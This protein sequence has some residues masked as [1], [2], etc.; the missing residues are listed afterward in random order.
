MMTSSDPRLTLLLPQY[1]TLELTRLCL[2]I[3]RKNLDLNEVRVIVID[4]D[5]RDESLEYL[6]TVPWI[7]LIE[8][9][10]IPGEK[11]AE[12]HTR[13]L[14]MGLAVT[15]TEFVMSMHTD[16]FFLGNGAMDLLLDPFKDPA[17]AG[18]GSWKLEYVSPL[19]RFGKW[20]EN[21][22]RNYI[23]APLTGKAPGSATRV[24]KEHWFLRRHCAV[25]RTK[26]LKEM[27]LSFGDGET[28]GKAIHRKLETAGY[29]ML[30]L[31]SEV[32]MEHLLHL[33]HATMILNPET[34]GRKTAKPA[35]RRQLQKALEK[36]HYRDIQDAPRED[37]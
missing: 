33:D 37:C 11:P 34:G 16:T 26:L 13:A 27:Q 3:I 2:R 7:T 25:Y 8:R 36:M 29:K 15:D 5:S 23:K 31:P 17:V 18:T 4:N 24:H 30:F 19:K 1:K 32:L 28:A 10:A 22:F 35:A 21:L 9:T 20:L 12:A 14:D 6:R